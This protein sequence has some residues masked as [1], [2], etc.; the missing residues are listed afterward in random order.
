MTDDRI[1]TTMLTWDFVNRERGRGVLQGNG[2]MY[3]S[4]SILTEAN[5]LPTWKDGQESSKVRVHSVMWSEMDKN[6]IFHSFWNIKISFL[7]EDTK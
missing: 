1:A 6:A 5:L 4:F 7:R 3:I 2:L